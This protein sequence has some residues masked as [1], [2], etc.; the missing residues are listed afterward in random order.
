MED[1]I[2]LN[3]YIVARIGVGY[4]M[5]NMMKRI[6]NKVNVKDFNFFNQKMTMILNL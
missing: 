6:L 5:K 3:A 4:V 2:I 1:V